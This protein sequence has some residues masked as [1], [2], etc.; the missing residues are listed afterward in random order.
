MRAARRNQ[1]VQELCAGAI[2]CGAL[3]ALAAPLAEAVP[4]CDRLFPA[5]TKAFVSVENVPTFIDHYLKTEFGQLLEDPDVRPFRDDLDR[6]FREKG[7]ELQD[8]LGLSWEDLDGLASGE[9]ALG[10]VPGGP[11]NAVVTLL[12]DVSQSNELAQKVLAK[13]RAELS[14][15]WWRW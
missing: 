6:Q 3:L 5:T 9:M 10:I 15:G 1:R 7:W 4:P 8:R 14:T 11:H 13:V 2:S 12:V